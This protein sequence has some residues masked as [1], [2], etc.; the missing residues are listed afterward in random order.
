M[1]TSWATAAATCY[2]CL[3]TLSSPFFF[4]LLLLLS[5]WARDISIHFVLRC[6]PSTGLMLLLVTLVTLPICFRSTI[7]LPNHYL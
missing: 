3:S 2:V 1:P 5:V 6:P 7:Y 4:L